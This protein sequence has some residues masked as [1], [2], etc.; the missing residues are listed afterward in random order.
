MAKSGKGMVVALLGI[1]IALAVAGGVWYYFDKKA[2]DERA[3]AAA[4]AF[5]KAK[6]MGEMAD[7][8]VKENVEAVLEL[9]NNQ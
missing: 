2:R 6:A 1:V 8:A 4:A 9:Q 5:D 7:Q 3:A